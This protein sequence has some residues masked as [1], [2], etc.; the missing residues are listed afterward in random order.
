M[1]TEL[2]SRPVMAV[3][4]FRQEHGDVD[5]WS[6]VDWEVHQNLMEIAVA[7]GPIGG[8]RATAG[9]RAVAVVVF[10]Y[11]FVLYAV[12][13]LTSAIRGPQPTRLVFHLARVGRGP[14]CRAD[15][16]LRYSG[17]LRFRQQIIRLAVRGTGAVD[18]MSARLNRG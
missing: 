11:A 4:Q 17:D 18:R 12:T 16:R 15:D 8:L 2:V 1:S 13:E 5:S 7:H 10:G 14:G 9:R 6:S 3:E